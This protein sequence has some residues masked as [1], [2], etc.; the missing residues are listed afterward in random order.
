MRGE[1]G[2]WQESVSRDSQRP[3][4]VRHTRGW[5]IACTPW[6]ASLFRDADEHAAKLPE[7][8]PL[9]GCGGLLHRRME[10]FRSPPGPDWDTGRRVSGCRDA[11]R[12]GSPVACALPERRYGDGGGHSS[13]ALLAQDHAAEEAGADVEL[14]D[15]EDAA[16]AP[17]SCR[18]R[19][20]LLAMQSRSGQEGYVVTTSSGD[21]HC[22]GRK[23]ARLPPSAVEGVVR[24]AWR[25]AWR[26]IRL[27][28]P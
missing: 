26:C 21:R 8:L 11:Y 13:W 5:R 24:P 15:D 25:G 9:P 27:S 10:R 17:R 3:S 7:T 12:P 1:A 18:S 2:H 19:P 16:E 14:P 20:M 22:R 23:R 4:G 28:S 6:F